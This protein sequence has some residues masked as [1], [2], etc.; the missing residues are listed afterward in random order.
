MDNNKG[1][2]KL[3]SSWW[4]LILCIMIGGILSVFVLN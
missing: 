4:L 1:E 3:T 2:K